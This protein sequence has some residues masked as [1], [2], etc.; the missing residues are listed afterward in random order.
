MTTIEPSDGER[1]H[2]LERELRRLLHRQEH[3]RPFVCDGDPTK[4]R[5]FIVGTNPATTIEKSFWDFWEI[6]YGF[7]K[8]EWQQEYHAARAAR[9]RAGE[10]IQL[11]SPTR[12]RIEWIV[13]AAKPWPCLETN[14]FAKPARTQADLELKDRQNT[15]LDLLLEQ[16]RPAVI[17]AHGRAAHQHFGLQPRTEVIVVPH[18]FNAPKAAAVS[19][20]VRAKHALENT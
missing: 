17:I 18:L 4:C 3:L 20:G 2:K 19:Y 13:A 5:I 11:T 7:K 12:Q 15:I 14:V 1:L 9:R 10:H 16:I 8:H 6:G